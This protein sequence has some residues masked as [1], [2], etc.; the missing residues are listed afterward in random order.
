M[1]R[2]VWIVFL[3]AVSFGAVAIPPPLDVTDLTISVLRS[4][5][6]NYHA[7]M[8]GDTTYVK[9]EFPARMGKAVAHT[10]DVESKALSGLVLATTTNWV[11]DSK[12][13]MVVSQY[14]HTQTDLS[15]SVSY[16]CEEQSDNRCGDAQTYRINSVSH[17]VAESS[18]PADG[19]ARQ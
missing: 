10:T 17:L 14:N 3:F 8:R 1:R 4:K 18:I 19:K 7:W 16:V 11:R 2:R 13:L 6:F 9:L 5:G 15:I 12:F